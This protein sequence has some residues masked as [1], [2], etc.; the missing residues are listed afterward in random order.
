MNANQKQ[1]E[2]T[3]HAEDT[4]RHTA[5]RLVGVAGFTE[6]DTKDIEQELS[7]DLLQRLP[8]FDLSKSSPNTFAARII[9]NKATKLIRDRVREKRDYRR[10]YYSLN[11][12]IED[13]DG[14]A[15][16][17]AYSMDYAEAKI[18]RG[19]R[20]RSHQERIQLRLDVSLIISQ[21]PDSLQQIAQLLRTKTVTEAAKTLGMPRSTLCDQISRLRIIFEDKGLHEYL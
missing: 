2:I 15:I 6:N 17:R 20:R 18:R 19:N 14:E 16:D 13:A 10:E 8:K 4:I 7:L 21:L 11:D 12:P 3:K 9:R 5:R 1:Y